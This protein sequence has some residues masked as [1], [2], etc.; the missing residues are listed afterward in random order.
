MKINKLFF[1]IIKVFF[2]TLI[3]TSLFELLKFYFFHNIHS[4]Y[5]HISTILFVSFLGVIFSTISHIKY[6]KRFKEKNEIQKNYEDLVE[7]SNSI[8]LKMNVNGQIL[9]INNFAVSF[10]GYK[11]ED[12]IGKNVLETITPKYSSTGE[13]LENMIKDLL[14]N[15]HKYE[16]NENEN[17]LKDGTRVWI[18]WT[19]KATFDEKGNIVEILSIGNDITKTKKSEDALKNSRNFHIKLLDNFPN[20]IWIA[21]SNLNFT[22]FNKAWLDFTGRFLDEEIGEGWLSGIHPEDLDNYLH[23]YHEAFEEKKTFNMKFR[24]MNIDNQY[25]WID[26]FGI[27]IF[28]EDVFWGYIGSCYDITILKNSLYEKQLLLREIHHRVKNNLQIVSSLLDLECNKIKDDETLNFI[29]ECK[30]RIKSMSLIHEWLYNSLDFSKIDFKKYSEK[31]INNLFYTYKINTEILSYELDINDIFLEI[32]TAIPCGLILNELI[33]N[34]LKHAF[35]DGRKGNILVKFEEIEGKYNFWIID[36][37][38]G[39]N[40]KD[41]F[42]ESN[43]VGIVLVKGLVRQLDGEIII[44]NKNGTTILIVLKKK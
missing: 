38:I 44:D 2:F 9:F 8:I 37:G 15:T 28:D 30:N 6:I 18:S 1:F 22:Y 23:L 3:F 35:N 14:I 41:F 43:S 29:F 24:L 12:I 13:N 36:N 33:T 4:T 42:Y 27:P 10:F 19:N 20:P 40:S 32:E 21:N 26:V 39:L 11:K 5:L 16:I 34:C 17:I 7:L 25:H 31:L